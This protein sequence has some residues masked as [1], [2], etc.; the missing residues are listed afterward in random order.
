VAGVA[1]DLHYLIH[2]LVLGSPVELPLPSVAARPTDFRYRVSLGRELSQAAT[3]SRADD[4]D[5]PW[6]IEHWIGNGLAVEFPGRATFELSRKDVAL[7]ADETGDPDLVAHLLLDH[8]VPRLVA[9]RGDLMLHAAGAVGPSGHAHLLLGKT[10]AGKSTTVV[11]LVAAGWE[12]LDDDGIRIVETEKA[13]VAVP[14]APSIRLLPPSAKA[15]LPNVPSGPPIASENPKR[16]FHAD[17]GGFRI[18]RAA[19]P[20]GCVYLLQRTETEG[21]RVEPLGLADAMNT[22]VEHGYHVTDEP[23]GIARHAF[24][25]A[26]ALAAAAPVWRLLQPSGLDRVDRTVDLLAGLD[27]S[28][29]T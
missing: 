9:L 7:V 17:H 3:H 28:L 22:I 8:V 1:S 4:P 23:A 18:A 5:D 29:V 6:A 11:S 24:N 13:V 26:T 2:G 14:G 15:F 10:G 21:P 19:A 12:L 25:R 20:V 16:H 27:E